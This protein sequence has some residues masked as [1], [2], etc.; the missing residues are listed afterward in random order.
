M[1]SSTQPIAEEEAAEEAEVMEVE[2]EV[3]VDLPDLPHAL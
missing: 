3:E 2:V 1:L